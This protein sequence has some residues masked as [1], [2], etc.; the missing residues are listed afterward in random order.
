MEKS[1]SFPDIEKSKL[2]ELFKRREKLPHK[3]EQ[4]IQVNTSDSF[5][6][7]PTAVTS[8]FTAM[9]A[10]TCDLKEAQQKVADHKIT[11]VRVAK[12]SFIPIRSSSQSCYVRSHTDTFVRCSAGPECELAERMSSTTSD[13][14]NITPLATDSC[15][16]GITKSHLPR[17]TASL[18]SRG[19][20][21]TKHGSLMRQER[22]LENTETVLTSV[23]TTRTKIPATSSMSEYHWRDYS[24][25]G[26]DEILKS[27]H[28]LSSGNSVAN[29]IKE[30]PQTTGS[31]RIEGPNNVQ[32]PSHKN[33][34]LLQYFY[35]SDQ[36]FTT[37]FES[38]W[39][40]AVKSSVNS[41]SPAPVLNIHKSFS[42]GILS[43]DKPAAPASTNF[44]VVN[45]VSSKKLEDF[46]AKKGIL[47]DDILIVTQRRPLGPRSKSCIPVRNRALSNEKTPQHSS[48]NSHGTIG[49][50]HLGKF[51]G[52]VASTNHES[53]N[54]KRN[55]LSK[56]ALV[57]QL[58]LSSR[59]PA[60]GMT[61]SAI[62]GK[63]PEV[64][65][66][67]PPLPKQRFRSNMSSARHFTSKTPK[68]ELSIQKTCPEACLQTVS[69]ASSATSSKKGLWSKQTAATLRRKLST[70]LKSPRQCCKQQGSDSSTF[71]LH[72]NTSASL[73]SFRMNESRSSPVTS[74][75]N[76][77]QLNQQS[78]NRNVS[79]QRPGLKS[80]S[81]PVLKQ[82]KTNESAHKN[83][84]G[85]QLQ[86][87]DSA[88][89]QRQ[90]LKQRI[91]KPKENNTVK[92][93][94]TPNWKHH[95]QNKSKQIEVSLPP[96]GH[97]IQ[98]AT[99]DQIMKPESEPSHG[100]S[101]WP[102][103]Q[104]TKSLLSTVEGNTHHN[105]E[106]NSDKITEPQKL[107]SKLPQDSE[108]ANKDSDTGVMLLKALLPHEN[109]QS[110]V[111]MTLT[112]GNSPS[113]KSTPSCT[114]ERSVKHA[115]ISGRVQKC[116]KQKHVKISLLAGPGRHVPKNTGGK[117]SGHKF[118]HSMG[119]LHSDDTSD[120][121]CEPNIT[122]PYTK[123][124][125]CRPNVIR[126]E[127]ESSKKVYERERNL[128]SVVWNTS[129][130]EVLIHSS[131]SQRSKIKP[132]TLTDS[133]IR[134]RTSSSGRHL[135]PAGQKRAS[136]DGT[137]TKGK[138]LN[139]Q[140]SPPQKSEKKGHV[141]CDSALSG[142]TPNSGQPKGGT[143]KRQSFAHQ[144][145]SAINSVLDK[146]LGSSAQSSESSQIGDQ[147]DGD[148][149]KIIQGDLE[150]TLIK[151]YQT[152]NSLH[153]RVI[154]LQNNIKQLRNGLSLLQSASQTI[155]KEDFRWEGTVY[156]YLMLLGFMV[157][158][159]CI[160]YVVMTR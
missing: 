91:V 156:D 55:A 71:R 141:N 142:A 64:K 123:H 104:K 11:S 95:K 147:D 133:K 115:V 155:S 121:D 23:R 28:K 89:N 110:P 103:D 139:K 102:H 57:P 66:N 99:G 39:Q 70:K 45:I 13:A 15:R 128:S 126:Q 62:Q 18:H 101:V 32:I 112:V 149:D 81:H 82:H 25:V 90:P 9:S 136:A 152:Q 157:I 31:S 48:K 135:T 46:D 148:D 116:G 12:K 137:R 86:P 7:Q 151:L 3:S 109:E 38:Q 97:Q 50:S 33:D 56:K 37:N 65:T 1:S 131:R 93:K 120:T 10:Q 43:K 27:W 54:I 63:V 69:P 6:L 40:T 108:P 51:S 106:L 88:D 154:T 113:A 150:E 144:D 52:I 140:R 145:W 124:T 72:S 22:Q 41:P 17:V 114:R 20:M 77:S 84:L 75:S 80:L 24:T 76:P 138:K 14:A 49:T 119:I 67:K 134:N 35:K 160:Q 153:I 132:H 127:L 60:V 53:N 21:K 68:Q 125:S 85:S 98:D 143:S 47:G 87:A 130:S 4:H 74:H 42:T 2:H 96:M 73:E 36:E 16:S 29:A 92:Q 61:D 5:C 34:S 107:A 159:F 79:V 94:K 117:D 26:T 44:K 122:R 30:N 83:M 59:H 58:T 158:E 19:I 111:L 78:T 105:S 8:D 146:Q 129:E 100:K 118:V